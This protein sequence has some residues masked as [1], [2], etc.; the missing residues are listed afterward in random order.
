MFYSKIFNFFILGSEGWVK[1]NPV[2]KRLHLTFDQKIEIIK[3]IEQ[4][5]NF[6]KNS[7]AAQIFSEKFK[8]P[9]NRHSIYRLMKE[10]NALLDQ[11]ELNK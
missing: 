3:F 10:K 7:K 11:F 1:D 5:D 9:I 4:N 2:R 6:G 8:L